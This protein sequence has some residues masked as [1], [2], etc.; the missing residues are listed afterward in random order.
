MNN[1][2]LEM[3]IL[4]RPSLHS[5]TSSHTLNFP[6]GGS[7]I[8]ERGFSGDPRILAMGVLRMENAAVVC[9]TRHL[10]GSG[11]MLLLA[12]FWIQTF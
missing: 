12:K 10:R 6:S 5:L 7:R 2:M 1:R 9:I 4:L 3:N 8:D 11:G